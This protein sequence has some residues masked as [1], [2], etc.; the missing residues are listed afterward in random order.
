MIKYKRAEGNGQ[1]SCLRCE[2]KGKWNRAW[3]CF[4]YKVEGKIGYYC[5]ECIKEM[6]KEE[7]K[8]SVIIENEMIFK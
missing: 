4:L 3:M 6:E 2:L 5:K 1:G 8:T 7:E